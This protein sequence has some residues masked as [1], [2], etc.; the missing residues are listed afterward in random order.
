MPHHKVG[1]TAHRSCGSCCRLRREVACLG[2][3]C[4]AGGRLARPGDGRWPAC[5]SDP[6]L[7][8]PPVPWT[9]DLSGEGSD[10]MGL[11]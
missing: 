10:L 2:S 6:K 9:V 11:I 4:V 3:G 1:F 7:A 8:A 5:R